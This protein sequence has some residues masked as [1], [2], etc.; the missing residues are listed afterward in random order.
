MTT[1]RNSLCSPTSRDRLVRLREIIGPHGLLPVSR[2]T[3]YAL[4][5][6]GKI[7]K[8]CRLSARTS[9][10]RESDILAYIASMEAD[11]D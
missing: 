5:A 10:W 8:A 7:P 9:A 2:S 11:N 3:F 6:A 4:V 1:T